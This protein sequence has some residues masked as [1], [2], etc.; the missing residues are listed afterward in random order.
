MPIC[1]AGQAVVLDK[2]GEWKVVDKD[3]GL[4]ALEMVPDTSLWKPIDN[5]AKQPKTAEQMRYCLKVDDHITQLCPYKYDVPKNAILG[6]GCSVQC[7]VCGSRFRDSCCA[8]CG[9]TRGR[10]ILMDCRICGKSY[11]H[12][13][14]MCPQRDLASSFTC[15]PYTGYF[16]FKAC[17]PKE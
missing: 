5:K 8:K 16:S 6:K 1:V 3:G 15:D 10:A 7:T 11:D 14:D 4:K 9:Q 12:W 2:D 17:P 13:P